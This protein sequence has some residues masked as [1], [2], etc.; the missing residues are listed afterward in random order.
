MTHPTSTITPLRQ[1]MIEDM[2]LRKLSPRTQ[3][4][5][6]RAVSKLTRFLRHSPATATAEEQRLLQLHLVEQA[7]SGIRLNATETAVRFFY[8][9]SLVRAEVTSNMSTVP[10][11]R[12]LPVVLNRDEAARL[13]GA[14]GNPKYRAAL[15]VAYGAGLRIGEVVALKVSDVDSKRM[16]LRVEQG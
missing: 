3:D 15:A 2:K 8:K 11:P 6:L 12:K 14:A 13:I 1:R 4:G 5:Y 9:T 16:T 7:S 10:V